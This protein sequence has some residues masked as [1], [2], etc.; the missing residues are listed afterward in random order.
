MFSTSSSPEDRAAI[1]VWGDELLEKG[2]PLGEIIALSRHPLNHA[3]LAR[4]QREY[5]RAHFSDPNTRITWK[6]G[7]IDQIVV[8]TEDGARVVDEIRRCRATRFLR[9]L[10]LQTQSSE[11]AADPLPLIVEHGLP[12]SLRELTLWIRAGRPDFRALY[13][14]VPNLTRLETWRPETLGIVD[15][16]RLRTFRAVSF[17]RADFAELAKARLPN[18]ERIELYSTFWSEFAAFDLPNSPAIDTLAVVRPPWEHWMLPH[19]VEDARYEREL[20]GL[21][22]SPIAQRVH[23]LEFHHRLSTEILSAIVVYA[24]WLERFARIRFTPPNDANIRNE[25]E[26]RLGKRLEWIL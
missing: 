26:Q 11:P 14:R 17:H 7:V 1:A 24:S 20:R 22:E 10:D 3:R 25:L 5:E 4:A 23:T 21:V 15:L 12:D 13:A 6:H 9:L 8:E 18:L 2:D 19:D 16:P